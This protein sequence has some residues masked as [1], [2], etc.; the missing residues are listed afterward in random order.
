MPWK[1][2]VRTGGKV[3]Q[4]R[5]G[6]LDPALDAL[7]TRGNELAEAAPR[8]PIDAKY[9]QFE[10]VQQVSAR[11][12]LAGPQRFLPN[13]RAGVDVRGD[14]SAEAYVGH[15]R[16]VGIEQRKDETAYQA[17]RRALSG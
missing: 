3:E 11:V 12:E 5:F 7:E 14:G 8:R 16:R 4:Q 6:E 1:V 10:P 15:V 13:V 17:L 9:K 2:T